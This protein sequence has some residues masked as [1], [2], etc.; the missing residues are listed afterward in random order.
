[1]TRRQRLQSTVRSIA[2]T[3]IAVT[4]LLGVTNV[5]RS[6]VENEALSTI[7]A[8]HAGD[9]EM[10]FLLSLEITDPGY[11]YEP[12]LNTP[13]REIPSQ[14][15][16][17]SAFHPNSIETVEPALLHRKVDFDRIDLNSKSLQIDVIEI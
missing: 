15:P 11:N 17:R 7:D 12:A 5:M 10:R 13:S 3:A 16:F 2:A 9:D 14:L 4:L 6:V 1:M 8:V